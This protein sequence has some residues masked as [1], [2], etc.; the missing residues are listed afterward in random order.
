MILGVI[1]VF[2][3][4]ITLPATKISLADLNPMTAGFAILVVGLVAAGRR[5]EIVTR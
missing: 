5:T 4:S 1:G 2:M 3:F